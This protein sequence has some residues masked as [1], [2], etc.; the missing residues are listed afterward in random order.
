MQD[1][2]VQ[3][4][5]DAACVKVPLQLDVLT[6]YEQIDRGVDCTSSLELVETRDLDGLLAI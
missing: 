4:G 2:S 3:G 1:M 6:K 5:I